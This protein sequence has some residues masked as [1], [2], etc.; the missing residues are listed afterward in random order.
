MLKWNNALNTFFLRPTL[1]NND[2]SVFAICIMVFAKLARP[3]GN[4][5]T[6]ENFP[7]GIKNYVY[8]LMSL[9]ELADYDCSYDRK[10]HTQFVKS[11][12]T[13]YANNNRTPSSSPCNLVRV[14]I[15]VKIVIGSS[16]RSKNFS[17]NNSDSY[18]GT[19]HSSSN[20]R[21]WLVP[22]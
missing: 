8:C 18:R 10:L 6:L 21:L 9:C 4:D 19:N 12:N 5:V 1:A 20:A 13:T 11:E 22:R 17:L 2:N 7:L 16:L 15:I 3:S 14:C